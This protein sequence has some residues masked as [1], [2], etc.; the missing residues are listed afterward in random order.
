MANVGSAWLSRGRS[1]S[2]SQPLLADEQ[3]ALDN[4]F[5]SQAVFY[6]LNRH[7]VPSSFPPIDVQRRQPFWSDKNDAPAFTIHKEIDT[8]PSKRPSMCISIPITA[9]YRAPLPSRFAAPLNDSV[10]VLSF[11]S[12][13]WCCAICSCKLRTSYT[14]RS[15]LGQ[16]RTSCTTREQPYSMVLC[17][18][19]ITVL[20]LLH[21]DG[22]FR[23][24]LFPIRPPLTSCSSVFIAQRRSSE[25][26]VTRKSFPSGGRQFVVRDRK[27]TLLLTKATR[28]WRRLF[29]L[30][31]ALVSRIRLHDRRLPLFCTALA[32]PSHAPLVA[33][34]REVHCPYTARTLRALAAKTGLG[35]KRGVGGDVRVLPCLARG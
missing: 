5:K 19:F 35:I 26:N 33:G 34:K 31:A 32:D 17:N 29:V 3:R 22:L 16:L 21:Q 11:K 10:L 14:T 13:S 15:P 4:R 1:E 30:S 18:I 9:D 27:S 8:A 7:D 20:A 6:V 23:S 25:G 28:I 12:C 2:A 24:N